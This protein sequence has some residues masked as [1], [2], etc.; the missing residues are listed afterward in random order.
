M[1]SRPKES[2][3]TLK[4]F[5]ERQ[6]RIYQNKVNH[7]FNVTDLNIEMRYLQREVNEL[8]EALQQDD[9][10][11]TLEEIADVVIYCYGMAQILGLNLDEMIFHKMGINEHR[12]YVVN[13]DTK[14]ATRIE[15]T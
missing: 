9:T 10:Q 13:Q 6:L 12:K 14:E 1:E 7:G 11:H 3:L 4:D 2:E 5:L 8:R 15:G